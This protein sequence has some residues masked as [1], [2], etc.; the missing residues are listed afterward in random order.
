MT[1]HP[2]NKRVLVWINKAGLLEGD[3][4]IIRPESHQSEPNTGVVLSVGA[5]ND[6]VKPGDHV[7]VERQFNTH[8][9]H[10][11][12]LCWLLNQQDIVAVIN[13]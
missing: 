6:D 5:G 11:G 4:L 2:I 10:E 13:K 1:I 12:K 8:V 7:V 3:S 9:S